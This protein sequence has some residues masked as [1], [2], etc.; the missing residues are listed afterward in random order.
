MSS[1]TIDDIAGG[2]N[3]MAVSTGK[4]IT[5]QVEMVTLVIESVTQ[6]FV[7]IGN[8]ASD[9]VTGMLTGFNQ[10]LENTASALAPKE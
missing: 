5:Q 6:V 7:P 4:I 3:E 10:I 9:V 1:E 2:I 8:T